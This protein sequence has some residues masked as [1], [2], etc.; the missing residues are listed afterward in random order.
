MRR[1]LRKTECME[2]WD[3]KKASKDGVY[4]DAANEYDVI[5]SESQNGGRTGER[6]CAAHSESF[7][8]TGQCQSSPKQA[9]IDSFSD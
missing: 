5:A 2:I 7:V 1:R 6:N 3:E 8:S 4:L 9:K